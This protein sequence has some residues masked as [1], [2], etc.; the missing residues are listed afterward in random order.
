MSD[1][2]TTTK[3]KSFSNQVRWFYSILKESKLESEY[4]TFNALQDIG[5][6]R[7]NTYVNKLGRASYK[8]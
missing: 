8:C 1:F 6:E 2:N 7:C 3:S 4:P 5:M